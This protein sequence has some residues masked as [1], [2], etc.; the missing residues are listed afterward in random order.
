MAGSPPDTR[1]WREPAWKLGE[2]GGVACSDRGRKPRVPG[3]CQL[4][5]PDPPGGTPQTP[6]SCQK[7]VFWVL[8]VELGGVAPWTVPEGPGPLESASLGPQTPLGVPP[9]TPQ[10]TKTTSMVRGLGSFFIA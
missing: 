9:Q 4:G 10:K 2:I 6:Q 5:A 8:F 1:I 3:I 7:S